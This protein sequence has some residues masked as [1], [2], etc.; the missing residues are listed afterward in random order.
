MTFAARAGRES[1]K[2]GTLQPV[3]A[4]PRRRFRS[5]RSGTPPPFFQTALL[6]GLFP[7]LSAGMA[8]AFQAGSRPSESGL[9][10]RLPGDCCSERGGP[11]EEVEVHI[12]RKGEVFLN[13]GLQDCAGSKDLPQLTA[14]LEG[15]RK[16]AAADGATL[17]VSFTMDHLARYER[18]VDVPGAA[19][20][21]G[22]GHLLFQVDPD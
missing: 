8:L 10:L 3:K 1:G 22:A 7:F 14:N 20:R 19:K 16:V 9:T 11:G 13:G 6:I 21:A 2:T 15:L 4:K 17:A 12:S 5:P 18:M